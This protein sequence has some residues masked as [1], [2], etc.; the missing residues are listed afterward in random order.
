MQIS[1]IKKIVSIGQ[2][3]DIRFGIHTESQPDGK[4]P[5]LQLRQFNEDGVLYTLPDEYVDLTD[6]DDAFLRDGDV[7]FVGKGNRHFAWCYR[8][9][10]G[11]FVASSSF[12]ILRP[13]KSEILPEYLAAILNLPQVKT[14]F[15][16]IGAGTNIFSIRKS[17]LAAFQI[18]LLP[19]NQQK[20]VVALAA[21]HQQEIILT[22]QLIKQKQNLYTSIISKLIK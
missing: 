22:Q 12:F 19:I 6:S 18:P 20:R 15:K 2:V 16:Q 4:V 5:Y 17:E 21:L 1:T 8:N 7:L 13:T 10:T 11:Q 14:S 9:Y 3:V